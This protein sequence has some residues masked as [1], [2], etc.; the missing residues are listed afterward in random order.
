MFTNGS[1]VYRMVHRDTQAYNT[2]LSYRLGKSDT[3]SWLRDTSVRVGVNNLFNTEPPLS[4][5][6]NNYETA[7]YNT[8][9]KGR[10]YSL[11]LTKKF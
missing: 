2:F 11:T 9:A 6:N 10:S 4:D 3:H 5:D 8:L 1:T 7:L